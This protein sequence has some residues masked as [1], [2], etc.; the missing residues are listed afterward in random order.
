MLNK[1][2]LSL[3][4]SVALLGTLA[5]SGPTYP[6]PRRPRAEVALLQATGGLIFHSLDSVSV[7]DLPMVIVGDYEMLPGGHKIVA[8]L[9]ESRYKT[10]GH[11]SMYVV[12]EAGHRYVASPVLL[13]N[14]W[15]AQV[16]DSDTREV[17]SQFVT[18]VPKWH[19]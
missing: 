2:S 3:A 15:T 18:A 1:L 16:M 8:A 11:M 12:M 19:N 4:L 17:V 7:R 6:G 10:E 9:L 13:G 5:C 14:T